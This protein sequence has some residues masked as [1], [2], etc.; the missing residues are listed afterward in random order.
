MQNFNLAND[1]VVADCV[2]PFL[3][4]TQLLA[5]VCDWLSIMLTSVEYRELTIAFAQQVQTIEC[6]EA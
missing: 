2:H 3:V 1:F 6:I 5:D 4:V